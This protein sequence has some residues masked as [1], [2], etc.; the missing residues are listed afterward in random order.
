MNNEKGSSA[1]CL[2][3]SLFILL[4]Y[5]PKAACSKHSKIKIKEWRRRKKHKRFYSISRKREKIVIW[6]TTMEL[7][8]RERCRGIYFHHF[9][10]ARRRTTLYSEHTHTHTRLSDSI[11]ACIFVCSHS[12][13]PFNIFTGNGFRATSLFHRPKCAWRC[14]SNV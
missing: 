6:C 3:V 13:R 8:E 14:Q 12:I 5:T 4:L 1:L 2:L 10:V 7:S 9:S 11:C